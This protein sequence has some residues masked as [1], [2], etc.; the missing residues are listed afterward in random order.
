MRLFSHP[1]KPN[2][3]I[4][5]TRHTWRYAVRKTVR[6]FIDDQCLDVA[7]ALTYW[8]VLSLFPA[9]VVLLSLV[10]LVGQGTETVDAVLAILRDL[11][12]GPVAKTLEPTLR[13]LSGRPGAGLTFALGL[14]AALWTAS[15]YVGAFARAMNRIYEVR[16][17]RPFLRRRALMLL[18]TVCLLVLVAVLLIGLVLSGPAARAVGEQLGLAESTIAT[19]NVAKWPVMLV[20][21][22]LVV[23]L[24]YYVTPNIKQPKLHWLSVGALVALL[25]GVAV[26]AAFGFY[27][28]EF[29]RYDEVYGSLASVVVFVLWLWL[30]N[31]ALLFG[32]EVASEVERGRQLQAGIPAEKQLQLPLR[33][34]RGLEKSREKEAEDV[35]RGREIRETGGRP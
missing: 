3:P 34:T 18:V 32:A 2:L 4:D 27:V 9:A 25:A 10:G 23:A 14:A 35:R 8:A 16:E 24:L 15:G 26:T 29:A 22:V 7:A 5:L 1:S 31:L 21:A 28:T 19:Y 12:G 11:G 33:D 13:E 30:T 6:E 20:V 17:G